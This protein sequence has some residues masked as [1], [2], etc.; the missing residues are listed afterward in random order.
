MQNAN[1]TSSPT[2]RPLFAASLL[3]AAVA[4]PVAPASPQEIVELPGEDRWLEPGYQEVFRLGT[5]AGQEW[6][7]FGSVR[8]VAFDETDEL[9]VET[10]LVVKFPRETS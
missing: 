5:L 1:Q 4:S 7:Q 2:T 6:E 3:C 10:V 8:S 9:G